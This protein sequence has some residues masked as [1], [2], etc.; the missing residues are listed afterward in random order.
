LTLINII[1]IIFIMKLEI[2]KEQ[3]ENLY[4]SKENKIVCKELGITNATLVSYL[5]INNITRKGRGNRKS[6]AKVN[7]I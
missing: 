6:K 3:L 4:L 7:I 1:I 5:K 2:T